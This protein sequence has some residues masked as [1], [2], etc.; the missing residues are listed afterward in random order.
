MLKE[1][2][3]Q[4]TVEYI[5]VMG[6]FFIIIGCLAYFTGEANEL[7]QIMAA[8]RSGA[9]EGSVVDSMAIY[10]QNAFS[11]YMQNHPRLLSPSSVRIVKI[12]YK[13]QG[14]NSTYNRT[15]IQLKI[16]AS[17]PSVTTNE[18]RNCLGDRLN[19]YA[20]KSISETFK[21]QN[22]TNS[23]FNPAFSN[24]YLVT[25]GDVCWV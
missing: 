5:L 16:Y 17:A 3:G 18:D 2:K 15:K 1:V 23:I 24:R 7:N 25:T 20:R 14:F 9:A 21:T 11:D 8:A 6:F 22:L 10:P 19:Y 4:F 12:E 13:N